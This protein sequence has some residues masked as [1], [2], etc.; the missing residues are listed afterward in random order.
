MAET[1][2]PSAPKTLAELYTEWLYGPLEA[3][4]Q[5]T[6]PPVERL[7][8][9]FEPDTDGPDVAKKADIDGRALPVLR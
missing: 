6:A 9:A 1:P 8:L 2:Q 4:R 3:F 5:H 7:G